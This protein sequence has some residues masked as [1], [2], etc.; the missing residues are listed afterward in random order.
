MGGAEVFEDF[1]DDFGREGGEAWFRPLDLVAFV[2]L[3]L[4]TGC[5]LGMEGD[6]GCCVDERFIFAVAWVSLHG[7]RSMAFVRCVFGESWVKVE[8]WMTIF[9]SIR[10]QGRHMLTNFTP[11]IQQ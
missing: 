7:E 6:Y 3:A 5:A 1:E 9:L 2:L 10:A 11:T 4:E 8:L